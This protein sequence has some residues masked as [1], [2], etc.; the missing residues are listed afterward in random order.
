MKALLLAPIAIIIVLGFMTQLSDIAMSTSNKALNFA[1]DM[2]NAMDCASRG[3]PVQECSPNLN[4]QDFTPEKKEFIDLN[5]KMIEM[6]GIDL[7]KELEKLK[8]I[9]K[10]ELNQSNV[11]IQLQ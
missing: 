6:Y 5:K 9:Q 11:S 10:E 7:E 8:E 2:N 4:K 3:I 1:D